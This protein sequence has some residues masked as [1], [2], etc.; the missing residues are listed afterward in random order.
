MVCG[1]GCLP[2]ALLE[3]FCVSSNKMPALRQTLS[4]AHTQ[5]QATVASCMLQQTNV[6][7]R[8]QLTS[9]QCATAPA[10]YCIS[11]NPLSHPPLAV[12]AA[13][14]WP[15]RKLPA[16]QQQQQKLQQ[17]PL[18]AAVRHRPLPLPG[19]RVLLRAA[20]RTLAMRGWQA[21]S[22]RHR[23]HAQREPSPAGEKDRRRPQ[24]PYEDE[25]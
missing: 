25:Q 5:A 12:G 21:A 9:L 22:V 15:C 11:H 3:Q 7:Q 23:W 19:W 1:G 10:A 2:A 13:R 20:L 4:T 18:P 14:S 8:D 17:A 6:R 16:A 24:Q